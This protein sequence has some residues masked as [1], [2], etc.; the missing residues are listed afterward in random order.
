MTPEADQ[1]QSG[2]LR[3][4]IRQASE[5]LRSGDIEA[6]RALARRALGTPA[7]AEPDPL[8]HEVLGAIAIQDGDWEE[9]YQR[10]EK[11]SS[12]ATSLWNAANLAECAWRTGRL[13]RALDCYRFWSASDPSDANAFLGLA[14]TLHGLQ[15]FDEA[16]SALEAAERLDPQN[17]RVRAR[18]GCLHASLSEFDAAEREFSKAAAL[19]A[20]LALCRVVSF[21]RDLFAALER[22]PDVPEP[23]VVAD[24]ESSANF[25]AVALTSCD[26]LYFEKYGATFL[27]S[28]AQNSPAGTL[29]HLH[30]YD[31]DTA[32][33]DHVDRQ[34]AR[35]GIKQY[36]LSASRTRVMSG[37]VSGHDYTQGVLY[38][39][40]RFLFLPAWIAKYRRPIVAL[41][42]DAVL[43]GGLDRY[44]N[45]AAGRDAGLLKREPA[46]APW[47]D[48]IAYITVANP[49]PGGLEYF[50]LVRNYIWH[51]LR[52]GD[53]YWHLD[54]IALY[55]CLHMMQRY[56]SPP[57]VAWF[58]RGF[59]EPG[60]WHLGHTYDYKLADDRIA[61]YRVVDDVE[62]VRG[63]KRSGA[64][65]RGIW[66]RLLGRAQR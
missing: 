28:F 51:F 66:R 47:L 60:V 59:L 61:R 20:S 35:C 24:R 18:R 17:A 49:T 8:L 32:L 19:D 53:A 44:V 15:R 26:G 65:L 2:S 55:C 1:P 48:I 12:S 21:N 10:L 45:F 36:V 33:L 29:L 34:L 25:H 39:C 54:Q 14:W 46:D 64:F 4:L 57:G 52:A 42:I 13:D 11:V 6:A 27:A 31:P 7:E 9:A 22:L 38:S 30:L 40:G 3:D 63:G 58:T 5:H 56:A 50:R 43:Q 16:R 41:D 37:V 23:P 62:R